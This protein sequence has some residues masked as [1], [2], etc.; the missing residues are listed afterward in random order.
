ME[1]KDINVI[2]YAIKVTIPNPIALFGLPSLMTLVVVPWAVFVLMIVLSTLSV[3]YYCV[4]A[5]RTQHLGLFN[6]VKQIALLVILGYGIS[7]SNSVSALSGLLS[8]QTGV[9]LRTPKYAI[10]GK[11]GTWKEKKYQLAL[12]RVTVFETLASVGGIVALAYAVFLNNLGIIPI[13]AVYVT[14]YLLVLFLTLTQ[15]VSKQLGS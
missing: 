1:V 15:S 10:T 3:L 6:N 13:L 4:E 14:G 7:V 5:V 11:A 9:F 2:G 8:K 12:N